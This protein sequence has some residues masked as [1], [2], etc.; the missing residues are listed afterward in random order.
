MNAASPPEVTNA[1]RTTRSTSDRHAIMPRLFHSRDEGFRL[2]KN[3]RLALIRASKFFH[4]V[5]RIEAK[6][7]DEFHFVAVLANKQFRTVVSGDVSRSDA[8]ENFVAQHVLIRL[9]VCWFGPAVPAP[10]DHHIP[11]SW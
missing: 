5:H 10:R 9:C 2:R 1:L 7:R 11:L 3:H 6:Q 4:R 8:R